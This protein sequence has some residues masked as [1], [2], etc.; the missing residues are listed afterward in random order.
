MD[1][2]NENRFDDRFNN[3]TARN[4]QDV[5]AVDLERL[6]Q[7]RIVEENERLEEQRLA[8]LEYQADQL[9]K[10]RKEK[11]IE[12][13]LAYELRMKE[14]Q[15]VA[16]RK[17]DHNRYAMLPS[18]RYPYTD[19]QRPVIDYS[20]NQFPD[21]RRQDFINPLDDY[22]ADYD[23]VAQLPQRTRFAQQP[24]PIAPIPAAINGPTQVNTGIHKKPIGGMHEDKIVLA[25]QT[26][27]TR[28]NQ[29]NKLLWFMMLCSLGLNIYLGW[30]ARS[31]FGRYEELADELRETFTSSSV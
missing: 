20:N 14:I 23:R 24:R 28:L 13:R 11:E 10:Q 18:S 29:Q 7:Q 19:D 25:D 22:D 30:I 5:R 17:R 15:D 3:Q 1:N 2:R 21:R 9:A 31:F 27:L 12:E 16:V 6:R 8:N 26:Q 4:N